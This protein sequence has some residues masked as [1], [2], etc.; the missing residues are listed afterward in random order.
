MNPEPS[1]SAAM[2]AASTSALTGTLYS[3]PRC[4]CITAYV[5]LTPL[6][7][8]C[9]CRIH[10]HSTGDIHIHNTKVYMRM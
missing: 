3:T 9:A 8:C 7:V 1:T 2:K 10:P 6:C 5:F 4:T